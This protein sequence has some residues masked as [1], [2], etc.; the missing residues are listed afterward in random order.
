MKVWGIIHEV[1]NSVRGVGGE[2]GT[3]FF[4]FREVLGKAKAKYRRYRNQNFCAAEKIYAIY[5][6]YY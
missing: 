6:Y 4:L 2:K 1:W 3:Y 5:Y